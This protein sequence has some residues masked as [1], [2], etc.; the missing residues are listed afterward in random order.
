MT[1]L[2]KSRQGDSADL[3]VVV[4]DHKVGSTTDG[5]FDGLGRKNVPQTGDHVGGVR[6]RFLSS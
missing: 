3:Q 5:E 2:I 6:E 4:L 1:N